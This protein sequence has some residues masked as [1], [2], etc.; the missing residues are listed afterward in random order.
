[1][2]GVGLGCAGRQY[3]CQVSRHWLNSLGR[4]R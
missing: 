4:R 2:S 3:H 1:L